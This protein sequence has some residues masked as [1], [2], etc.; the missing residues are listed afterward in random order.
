M[1]K[2]CLE[3]LV[4]RSKKDS[5]ISNYSFQIVNFKTIIANNKTI[6]A[7]LENKSLE[8]NKKIQKQSLALKRTRQIIKIGFFGGLAG[9]FIGG[10]L[11][12]N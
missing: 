10:L 11:L 5:I 4:N 8:N 3:C 2:K 7:D 6:I 1:D 9:G 12:G